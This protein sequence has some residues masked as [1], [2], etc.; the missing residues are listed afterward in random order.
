MDEPSNTKN[1]LDYLVVKDNQLLEA[2]SPLSLDEYRLIVS[3]IAKVDPRKKLVAKKIT[4]TALEYAENWGLDPKTAYLQLKKAAEKLYQQS[5]VFDRHNINDEFRWI[6]R[7]SIYKRGTG[8][9]TITFADDILP[10]LTD[11]QRN[12][13]WYHLRHVRH[14]RS[15]HSVRLYELLMRHFDKDKGIGF[16]RFANLEDF[17]FL[18]DIAGKYDEYKNL[19]KRVI[20]PAVKELCTHTNLEVNYESLK[21]GRRITGLEFSMKQKIEKLP[22]SL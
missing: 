17:R 1:P 11:L 10:Y 18:M 3:A 7:K 22:C 2:S 13:T 20:D 21:R 4:I 9:I 5:I 19:R 16:R 12:F 15:T 14:L 6:Q 8:Q